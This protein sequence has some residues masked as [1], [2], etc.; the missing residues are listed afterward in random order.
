MSFPF[1][2]AA[3]VTFRW[4]LAQHRNRAGRARFQIHAEPGRSRVPPGRDAFVHELEMT[5]ETSSAQRPRRAF[6]GCSAARPGR[7]RR[8]RHAAQRPARPRRSGRAAGGGGPGRAIRRHRSRARRRPTWPPP[9]RPPT[10]ERFAEARRKA[11]LAE[12]EAQLAQARTGAA[13]ARQASSQMR[14]T[15]N[16]L[17]QETVKPASPAAGT[18][19]V[20]PGAPV[21]VTPTTQP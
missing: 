11:D 10:T 4:S 18:T 15:V 19:A 3:A 7:V 9:I 5:H 12:S 21:V 13:Q 8:L 1:L 16:E 2:A 6:V 17:Q 14:T 20:Q